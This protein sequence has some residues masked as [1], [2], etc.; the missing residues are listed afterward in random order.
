[1]RSQH[2]L[3]VECLDKPTESAWMALYLSG[4]NKNFLNATGLT[5]SFSRLLHRVAH[6][7]DILHPS[8]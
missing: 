7:Y 2:Y 4:T 3:T 6:F 1:M 8:S 5:R